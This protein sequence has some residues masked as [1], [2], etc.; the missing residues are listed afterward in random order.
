M[1]INLQPVPN[2]NIHLNQQKMG[3][4]GMWTGAKIKRK[5]KV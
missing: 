2:L 5:E 4:A 1:P 3:D